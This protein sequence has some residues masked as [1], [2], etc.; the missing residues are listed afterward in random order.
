M[1][2]W[3]E[4]YHYNTLV[5]RH[6]FF[7][8]DV[9]GRTWEIQVKSRERQLKQKIEQLLLGLSISA[10]RD[11]TIFVKF[12]SKMNNDHTNGILEGSIDNAGGDSVNPTSG[13][14]SG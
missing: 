4:I 5:C 14:L 9:L 1:T 12:K 6:R 8:W 11:T 7:L 2:G 13:V 10:S 3:I